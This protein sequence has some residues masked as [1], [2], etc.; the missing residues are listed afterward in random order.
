VPVGILQSRGHDVL[1]HFVEP[2]RKFAAPRWPPRGEKLV[3]SPT[4]QLGLGAQRLVEQ[5]PGRL[6]ATPLTHTTDPAAAPEALRTGRVLDD[7][8]ERH[9]LADD[10]LSHSRFSF[11]ACFT[12]VGAECPATADPRPEPTP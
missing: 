11:P 1:R 2:V 7:S 4:E 12:T 8:V 10:D 6:F 9:V 5:D 3:G